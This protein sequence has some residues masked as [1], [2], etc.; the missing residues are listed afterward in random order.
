MCGKR[1]WVSCMSK[2]CS[3]TVAVR[4][5]HPQEGREGISQL[6]SPVCWYA[7]TDAWWWISWKSIYSWVTTLLLTSLDYGLGSYHLT[8]LRLL[9]LLLQ[10][11]HTPKAL[12]SPT[13]LSAAL[14]DCKG[15]GKSQETC[16]NLDIPLWSPIL[17]SFFSKCTFPPLCILLSCPGGH[18]K[19]GTSRK[20]NGKEF[21]ILRSS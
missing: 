11:Y 15:K 6:L 13:G 18:Y 17:L 4:N 21:F 3:L 2:V 9:L 16:Q 8:P 19:L 12:Q 20:I 1:L 10:H 7:L 14:L 5:Y